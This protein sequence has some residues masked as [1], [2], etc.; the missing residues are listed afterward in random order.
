MK[1]RKEIE[2]LIKE[3]SRQILVLKMEIDHL[4]IEAYQL[5]DDEQQYIE[6]DIEV[7]VKKRP[8][9]K[10]TVR[11]GTIYWMENLIDEGTNQLY[12]IQRSRI[13]RKDGLWL[14]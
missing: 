2:D 8:L 14:L 12:P 7:V 3:K 9:T 5:C 6:E 1:T 4:K 10:K 11:Q 13:V